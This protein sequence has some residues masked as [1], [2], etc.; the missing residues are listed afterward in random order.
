MLSKLIEILNDQVGITTLVGSAIFLEEAPQEQSLPYIVLSVIDGSLSD[1][2]NN[3]SEID[4]NILRI[5]SYGKRLISENGADT[6]A[7][8]IMEA[9]RNAIDGRQIIKSNTKFFFRSDGAIETIDIS[10]PNRPL[11]LA[12]QEY[13]VETSNTLAS[14]TSINQ[15][16]SISSLSQELTFNSGKIMNLANRAIQGGNYSFTLASSGNLP[17]YVISYY[18][19]SNGSGTFTFSSDFEIVNDSISNGGTLTNNTT[20]LFSFIYDGSKVIVNV[21]ETSAAAI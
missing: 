17:G 7:Y 10:Y 18:I 9:V 3:T 11:K 12:I 16:E 21:S 14:D 6:G 8:T 13:N 15:T 4:Y 19:Q 20:Y 1:S 2:K 5:T